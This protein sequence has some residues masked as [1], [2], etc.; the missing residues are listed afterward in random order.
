MDKFEVIDKICIHLCYLLGG[1][2]V[3]CFSLLALFIIVKGISLLMAAS[4]TLPMI[5]GVLGLGIVSY[6]VGVLCWGER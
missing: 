6:I 5:I 1:L 2:M 3:V 4:I